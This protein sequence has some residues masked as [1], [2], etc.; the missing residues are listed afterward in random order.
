MTRGPRPADP[1]PVTGPIGPAER[2]LEVLGAQILDETL[3]VRLTPL[4]KHAAD[5]RFLAHRVPTHS[6]L[7]ELVS[8]SPGDDVRATIERIARSPGFA[9]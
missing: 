8:R 1:W 4:A 5:F 2:L 7:R 3:A 6:M 9:T